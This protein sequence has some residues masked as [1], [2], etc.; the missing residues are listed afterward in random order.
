MHFISIWSCRQ[1]KKC[2]KV[3]ESVG[4][5]IREVSAKNSDENQGK[6][7]RPHLLSKH[8]MWL[9]WVWLGLQ[10]FDKRLMNLVMLLA[11]ENFYQILIRFND[12]R[13]SSCQPKFHRSRLLSFALLRDLWENLEELIQA[14][15]ILLFEAVAIL[16]S[17]FVLFFW[18]VFGH[19]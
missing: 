4:P 19:L 9:V 2:E 14:G 18:I 13:H 6:F 1:P 16:L 17:C 5:V 11:L 12:I 7:V 15:N 10:Y 8:E 3:L